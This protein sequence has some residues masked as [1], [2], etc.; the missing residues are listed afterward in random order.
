MKKEEKARLRYEVLAKY[1]KERNSVDFA[2]NFIQ[3]YLDQ[4]ITPEDESMVLYA[5]TL[6]ETICDLD[7]VRAFYDYLIGENKK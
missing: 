2:M 1:K 7:S 3:T 5:Q 6:K 4:M